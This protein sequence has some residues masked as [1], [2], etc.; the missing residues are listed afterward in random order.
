MPGAV[1]A[2]NRLVAITEAFQTGI[3]VTLSDTVGTNDVWTQIGTVRLNDGYSVHV[4]QIASA[5]AGAAT[6]RATYASA[7]PFPMMWVGEISGTSGFDT[8]ASQLNIN[9]GTGTDAIS[10]G[11]TGT[12]AG[13]A[14]LVLGYQLCT[15]GTADAIAGTGFTVADVLPDSGFDPSGLVEHKRVTTTSAVA[16]TFT[17]HGGEGTLQEFALVLVFTE[18][19]E[20]PGPPLHVISSPMRYN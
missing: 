4:Y 10:S 5:A 2:G 16:A 12:L 14:S 19:A 11:N 13:A 18:T 8:E 20:V 15:D 7:V 3:G 1:T 17:A 9:P 6:I